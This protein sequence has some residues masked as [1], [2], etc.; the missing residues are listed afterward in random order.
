MRESERINRS[1]NRLLIWALAVL[2]VVLC[3]LIALLLRRGETSPAPPNAGL[4]PR[5]LLAIGGPGKGDAPDFVRPLSAA[6]APNGDIYVSDTGNRRVCV[7]TRNGRLS[8][9]L[10]V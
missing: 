5:P 10:A 3:V 7:F 8:G 9:S 4:A 6:W 2:V 1:E